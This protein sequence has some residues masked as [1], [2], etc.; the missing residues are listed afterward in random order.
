MSEVATPPS[1]SPVSTIAQFTPV[2]HEQETAPEPVFYASASA[3]AFRS[4]VSVDDR[5][6]PVSRTTEP[7]VVVQIQS[8]PRVEVPAAGASMAARVVSRTSPG[9][10]GSS[11]AD[12][13]QRPA[14][15]AGQSPVET[16]LNL[17][18]KSGGLAPASNP[19]LALDG[20]P[21]VAT[22]QSAM[23]GNPSS[24]AHTNES[25]T[26]PEA[27][28]YDASLARSRSADTSFTQWGSESE[29]SFVDIGGIRTWGRS[30][31]RAEQSVA[32]R[33][34][35]EKSQPKEFDALAAVFAAPDDPA[36]FS[37]IDLSATS[38]AEGRGER[39]EQVR[40]DAQANQPSAT[41]DE[42]GLVEVADQGSGQS[43]EG[44]FADGGGTR[45]NDLPMDPALG[46]FRDFELASAPLDSENAAEHVVD[47]SEPAP[48][49][50][51]AAVTSP[52][53]PSKSADSASQDHSLGQR[54]A[55]WSLSL[56]VAIAGSF[57]LA[58]KRRRQGI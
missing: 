24:P 6:A 53:E 31:S 43:L 12:Q 56:P 48:Q 51:T 29:G 3:M 50:T 9:R 47:G 5:P 25:G 37:R 39:S 40:C 21:T 54:S 14:A 2:A 41:L 26:I 1:A 52:A 30:A 38:A 34:S 8:S 11:A 20:E 33:P 55:R 22:G 13:P 15:G 23:P 45:S 58:V 42:G 36:S 17:G 4:F 44:V 57:L 19:R 10:A 28:I 49:T 7:A 32:D 27:V 35:S 16:T 18:A 46:F